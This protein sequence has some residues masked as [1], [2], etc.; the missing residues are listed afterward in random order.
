[1]T[2]SDIRFSLLELD[3]P[4]S[5]PAAIACPKCG[6][7]AD[8]I[9]VWGACA[10]CSE[11]L[12]KARQD[13]R[14]ATKPAPTPEPVPAVE[15]PAAPAPAPVMKTSHGA[16]MSPR[17][18]KLWKY[19][20]A[21]RKIPLSDFSTDQSVKRCLPQLQAALDATQD[22]EIQA[23][24]KTLMRRVPSARV[25]ATGKTKAEKKAKAAEYPRA[26]QDLI[27]GAIAAGNGAIVG[28]SGAGKPTRAKLDEARQAA[29][30]PADLMIRAKNPRAYFGRACQSLRRQERRVN[31][32]KGGAYQIG[33]PASAD[34][35]AG[36]P[37][38]ET[39]L[40]AKIEGGELVFDGS[41]SLSGEIREHFGAELAAESYTA[42]EVTDWLK[43]RVLCGYLGAVEF[44]S[45]GVYVPA[46]RVEEAKKI[47]D[48]FRPIFG[49]RWNTPLP[50]A[51][52]DEI[53]DGL[54]GGLEKEISDLSGR[55]AS[56]RE[57][58][59][60]SKSGDIGARRATTFIAEC[61]E[62]AE[63]V[64]GYGLLIG[65]ENVGKIRKAARALL[66]DLE[67]LAH[68]TAQRG[69]LIWEEIGR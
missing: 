26:D 59:K 48:A 14:Q 5:A 52:C 43:N 25:D 33:T 53:R 19:I 61:T 7:A 69:A 58:A 27:A 12:D 41:E 55:I 18:A 10:E 15:K 50:V 16:I 57:N 45:L 60:D 56:A 40:V 28:W 68:D 66:S 20:K 21:E 22:A 6:E 63:R 11:Q 38:G 51:T 34:V 37:Y 24:I 47:V 65:D 13:A 44:G 1:M 54:A 35:K 3:I 8:E 36:D 62:I 17:M 46:G 9:T 32:L 67:E 64:S 39:V 29:G 4:G 42:G 30:L 2:D 23:D 31:V 49:E